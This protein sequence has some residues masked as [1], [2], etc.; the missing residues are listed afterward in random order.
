MFSIWLSVSVMMLLWFHSMG[1]RT[2]CSSHPADCK[3][4][5]IAADG[6]PEQYDLDPDLSPSFRFERG[7]SYLV[8]GVS[9]TTWEMNVVAV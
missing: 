1:T 9:E 7:A 4:K 3:C 8:V 6:V 2:G 5:S